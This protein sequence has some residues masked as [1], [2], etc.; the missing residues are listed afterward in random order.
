MSKSK[1]MAIVAFLAV[2][3]LSACSDI[4]RSAY[5]GIQQ[6]QRQSCYKL[7]GYQRDDCLARLNTSYDDYEEAR[8][9][10]KPQTDH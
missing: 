7:I 2:L 10:K 4:N 1:M 6:N 9:D 3:S 5:N 8:S